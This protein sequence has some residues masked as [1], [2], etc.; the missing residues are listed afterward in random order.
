MLRFL[1]SRLIQGLLVI[2]GVVLLVFFLFNV[3]PADPA[4]LTMGQRSDISSLQNIRRE[5]FLDRP[6]IVQLALYLNDLSPLSLYDTGRREIWSHPHLVL[7]RTGGARVLV[8]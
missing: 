4:R 1:L 8:L 5:L 2:L 7:L 3:L 6:K